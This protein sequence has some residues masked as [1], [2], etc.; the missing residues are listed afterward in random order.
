MQNSYTQLKTFILDLLFPMECL[1][2]GAAGTYCCA[3]C[4]ATIP[5]QGSFLC[6]VCLRP[7]FENTVCRMCRKQTKLDG[8]IAA[9]FYDHRFLRRLITAYKY[10][11]AKEISRPL[12]SLLLKCLSQHDYALLHRGDLVLIPVPLSLRRRNWR[13]FNQAE[14]LAVFISE[15][16]SIPLNINT[17]RRAFGSV[18][19]VEMASRQERLENAKGVFEVLDPDAVRGRAVLLVDD[20]ATTLATMGECARVLKDAGAKEVWGSVVAREYFKA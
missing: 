19:Q 8:L 14:E 9:S 20:V 16:L 6:P 5:L 17:L 15:V 2:C 18:P 4:F 3:G 1:R 13:G 10:Q 7:S 12:A 11:F